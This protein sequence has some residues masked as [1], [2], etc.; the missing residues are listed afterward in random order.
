MK[1]DKP[2]LGALFWVLVGAVVASLV[3][4]AHLPLAHDD[5]EEVENVSYTSQK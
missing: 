3:F 5:T 4:L 1:R 2:V